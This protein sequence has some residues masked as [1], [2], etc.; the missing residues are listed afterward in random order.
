[1]CFGTRRIAV[2]WD[3]SCAVVPAGTDVGEGECEGGY[4]CACVLSEVCV[5]CMVPVNSAVRMDIEE[6]RGTLSGKLLVVT[7]GVALGLE[8]FLQGLGLTMTPAR[9]E[10]GRQIG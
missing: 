5:E 6:E 2:P 1:M 10:C 7:D 8:Q 4:T 3:R 9:G